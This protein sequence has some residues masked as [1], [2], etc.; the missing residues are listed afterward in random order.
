[1]KEEGA[2]VTGQEGVKN[3]QKVF[4]FNFGQASDFS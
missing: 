1:M 3:L 2:V 4:H